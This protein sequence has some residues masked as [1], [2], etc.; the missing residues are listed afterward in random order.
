[1]KKTLIEGLEFLGAFFDPDNSDYKNFGQFFLIFRKQQVA[2]RDNTNWHTNL[3]KLLTDINTVNNDTSMTI[4]K[5]HI[6]K[7]FRE[8][9]IPH[10]YTL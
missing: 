10:K 7:L 4:P 5:G 8:S 3:D 9:N 1:M 6:P 2:F